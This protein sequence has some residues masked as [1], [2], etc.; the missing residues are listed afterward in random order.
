MPNEEAGLEL[1][2]RLGPLGAGLG[3]HSHGCCRVA[4][5]LWQRVTDD[6]VIRVIDVVFAWLTASGIEE[7]RLELDGRVHVVRS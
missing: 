6:I 4:V 7:A 5:E 3:P 1:I 2:E